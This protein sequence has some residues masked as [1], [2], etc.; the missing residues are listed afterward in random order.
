MQQD[1]GLQTA[2]DGEFR[3]A[4]WHMDF[5]YQ[6]DGIS[7]AQDDLTVKF[8][9]AEGDIEFKPAAIH[10]GSQITLEKPIFAED[11][12]FLQSAVVEQHEALIA[13]IEKGDAPRAERAMKEH[14]LY[15]ADVLRMVEP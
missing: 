12:E 11:F 7:K 6:I 10:V 3:R 15:L 1:V 13:A 14:L 2:T 4:S 9:N 5:I 8:H